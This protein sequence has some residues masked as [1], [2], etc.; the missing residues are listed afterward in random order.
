MSFPLGCNKDT[1]KTDL[2]KLS[3]HDIEGKSFILQK[4]I[5]CGNYGSGPDKEIFTVSRVSSSSVPN[6]EGVLLIGNFPL[7]T[8]YEE[9]S[10]RHLVLLAE[11]P[12]EELLYFTP[13][14]LK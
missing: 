12:I 9:V 5:D 11:Y 4:V 6:S 3:Y 1:F 14:K 7:R 10:V 8:P 13:P 2:R